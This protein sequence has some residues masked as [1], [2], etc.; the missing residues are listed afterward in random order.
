MKTTLSLALNLLGLDGWTYLPD[1]VWSW[2]HAGHG[3]LHSGFASGL[4]IPRLY[5]AFHA[6]QTSFHLEKRVLYNYFVVLCPGR[7]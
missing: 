1:F 7:D 5:G 2:F 4:Q 3:W 6:L